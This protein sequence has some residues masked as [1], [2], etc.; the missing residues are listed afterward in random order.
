[1]TTRQLLTIAFAITITFVQEQ[2]LLFL[3]NVQF[4]VLLVILFV[5]IFSFRES[6]VY[7]IGYVLLDS[8]YMGG[9][10]LFY[11]VPMT[12]AWL[13]VPVM[14]HTLLRKTTNEYVLG[15]FAFSFGF[16]YGWMFIPFNMLQTGIYNIMPYLIADIPFELIMASTG[17]VT[18]VWLYKPLMETMNKILYT[19]YLETS[20]QLK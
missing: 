1:M 3:P 13:I 7:I 5:S 10:N 2:V 11:M 8:M 4:T 6:I 17:F 9:F 19:Q 16:L 18:V 20:N 14:Y 12:L 15:G